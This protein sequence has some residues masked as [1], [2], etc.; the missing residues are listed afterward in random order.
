MNY[1]NQKP[2][3][4]FDVEQFQRTRSFQETTPKIIEWVI[5]YSGGYVKEEQQASYVLIGFV[6]VAITISL[7]LIFSTVRSSSP[8]PADQ[9]IR[10]AG[11]REN[12][13]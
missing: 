10:V 12:L 8:P 7:F 9:I 6:G 13:K 3:I 5:K 2:Q 1:D 4:V 11:P